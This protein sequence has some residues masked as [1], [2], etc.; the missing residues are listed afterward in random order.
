VSAGVTETNS[1]RFLTGW[2][3]M[4]RDTVKR[5][6]AGRAGTPEDIADIVYLLSLAESRWIVGQTIVADGGYSLLA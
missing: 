5:T 4:L 6:P 1:L 2:E 3:E